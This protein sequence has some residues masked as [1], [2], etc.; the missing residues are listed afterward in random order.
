MAGTADVVDPDDPWSVIEGRKGGV[1]WAVAAATGKKLAEYP[2][3]SPPVFEGIAAA[4]G[5]LYIS[6]ADGNVVCLDGE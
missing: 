6:A 4:N 2:L 1:L 5:R 3:A